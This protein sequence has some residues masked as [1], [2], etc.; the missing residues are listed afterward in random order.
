MRISPVSR[1]GINNSKLSHPAKTNQVS[2]KGIKGAGIGAAGGILYLSVMSIV[3]A[4]FLPIT[5]GMAAI[6]AGSGALA[7]HTFE[8]EFKDKKDD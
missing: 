8:E 7:G 5:L 4:P 2:H 1:I 3:A 6:S